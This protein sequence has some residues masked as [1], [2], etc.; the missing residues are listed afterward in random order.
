MLRLKRNVDYITDRF[1]IQRALQHGHGCGDVVFRCKT[2]W[3]EDSQAS[4]ELFVHICRE[5]RHGM[6]AE[7]SR[8]GDEEEDKTGQDILVF[9]EDAAGLALI[10]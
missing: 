8:E 1:A 6:K 4:Q 2:G 9:R 3:V 5:F 10:D 7:V